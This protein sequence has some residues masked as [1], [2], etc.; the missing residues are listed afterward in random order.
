MM[1]SESLRFRMRRSQRITLTVVAA[2]GFAGAQ[3]QPPAGPK[4]CDQARKL[5][6]QNGTAVPQNCLANPHGILHGGF[7]AIAAH[8]KSGG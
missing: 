1:S 4:N 8:L 6:T 3:G 7:G 2:M 5:A